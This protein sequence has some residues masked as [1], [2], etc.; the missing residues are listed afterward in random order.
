VISDQHRSFARA[1]VAAAKESWP[2]IRFGAHFPDEVAARWEEDRNR[3]R[4]TVNTE[5]SETINLEL[6]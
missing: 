1:V 2:S 5:A 3:G 4:I 6:P